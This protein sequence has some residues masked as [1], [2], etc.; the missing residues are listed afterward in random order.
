MTWEYVSIP[1]AIFSIAIFWLITH[2]HLK[3][4][5]ESGWLEPD[6]RAGSFFLIS[7]IYSPIF[8]PF[9]V[10]LL[11]ANDIYLRY[12]MDQS[13]DHSL[14]WSLEIFLLSFVAAALA[15]VV[16]I[17]LRICLGVLVSA[18]TYE[19]FLNEFTSTPVSYLRDPIEWIISEMSRPPP[20]I[21]EWQFEIL[22]F[23]QL[24]L[25]FM[26]SIVQFF[27]SKNHL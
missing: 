6:T 10:G 13:L 26:D 3:W 16:N 9:W 11:F 18:A 5:D 8:W 23:S 12:F 22:I 21:F 14:W 15:I 20:E 2:F 1:G 27:G 17:S 24:V 19:W 7:Q 25:V 4:M